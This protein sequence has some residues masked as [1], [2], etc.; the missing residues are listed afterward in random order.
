MFYFGYFVSLYV[1]GGNFKKGHWNE[2]AFTI[3]SKKTEG[4]SIVKTGHQC[5]LK[6]NN[7]QRRYVAE[8]VAQNSTGGVKHPLTWPHPLTW[9]CLKI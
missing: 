7:L 2:V 5:K 9:T 4:D 8:K 3:N 6:W 1:L